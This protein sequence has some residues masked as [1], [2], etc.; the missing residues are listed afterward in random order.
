MKRC[1]A[2]LLAVRMTMYII[3]PTANPTSV[4]EVDTP[5][6][7]NTSLDE[8]GRDPFGS[9]TVSFTNF[10]PSTGGFAFAGRNHLNNVI[11]GGVR[12]GRITTR[13]PTRQRMA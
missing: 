7:L 2:R 9:G 6:D 3:N 13:C 11:A 10:A 12:R 5:D 4:I 8:N 1:T